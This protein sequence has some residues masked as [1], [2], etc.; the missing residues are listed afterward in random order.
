MYACMHVLSLSLSYKCTKVLANLT[1]A[2]GATTDF[3][4]A[5][6][7]PPGG[8]PGAHGAQHA[9]GPGLRGG[10]DPAVRGSEALKVELIRF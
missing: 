1:D 6:R 4:T 9:H 10:H 7:V 8:G 3:V 2:E 5:G